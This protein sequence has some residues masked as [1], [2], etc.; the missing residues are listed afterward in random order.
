[1]TTFRKICE[2]DFESHA[3]TFQKLEFCVENFL[4]IFEIIKLI[5]YEISKISKGSAEKLL[6]SISLRLLN[7]SDQHSARIT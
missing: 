2:K 1:M 5:G 7:T 6:N 3:I 4:N